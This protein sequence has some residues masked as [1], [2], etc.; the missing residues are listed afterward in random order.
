MALARRPGERVELHRT[1]SVEA[2]GDLLLAGTAGRL[3]ED[4]APDAADSYA[5]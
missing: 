4:R 3:D 1:G 5:R 2:D